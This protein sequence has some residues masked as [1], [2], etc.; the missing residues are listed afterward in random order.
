MRQLLAAHMGG[1]CDDAET[2]SHVISRSSESTCRWRL[3][4][5]VARDGGRLVG[6]NRETFYGNPG[7]SQ[8]LQ[9]DITQ[10]PVQRQGGGR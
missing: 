7:I 10:A 6:Y 4:R 9:D 1:P 5:W 8:L 2:I 3:D